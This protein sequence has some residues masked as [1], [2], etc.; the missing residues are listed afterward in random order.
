MKEIKA[1]VKP[2]RIQKI[3]EALTD[4]GFES[5]TLSQAEGTG[6]FKAKGAKPSLDFHIT[7]SPVVKVE[8]VCQNE[9]AQSAIDII[10]DN[11]KTPDP[12]DGIIY[13][14]EIE[15]AFQVKTGE[16]LKRYDL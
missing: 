14:S 4:N 3:I 16:S 1:F 9:E 15:D 10:L 8:L 13:L 2:N 11:G 6:A 5:M 7:D 12:G